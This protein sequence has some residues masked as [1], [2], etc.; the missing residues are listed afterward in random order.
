MKEK[1]EKKKIEAREKKGK[2]ERGTKKK[3]G[4]EKGARGGGRPTPAP[5][6][7]GEKGGRKPEVLR[8]SPLR[9]LRRDANLSSL[10]P[11]PR[12]SRLPLSVGLEAADSSL[13]LSVF[14]VAAVSVAMSVTV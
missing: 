14:R 7:P 8:C 11:H 3:V 12:P 9:H 1:E 4:G 10:L 5:G 6:T 13:A 2:K